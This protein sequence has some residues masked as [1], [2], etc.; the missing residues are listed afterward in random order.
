MRV[1]GGC[2]SSDGVEVVIVAAVAGSQQRNKGGFLKRAR[3]KQGGVV[4]GERCRILWKE[5]QLT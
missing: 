2:G 3:L 5:E 1:A 4:V